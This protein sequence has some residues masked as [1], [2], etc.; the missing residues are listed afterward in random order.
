[1]EPAHNPKHAFRLGEAPLHLSVSSWDFLPNT[2]LGLLEH[3]NATDTYPLLCIS[4][5]VH[6]V[7]PGSAAA[8]SHD[9]RVQCLLFL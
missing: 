2:V 6:L 8:L 9:S 1:M 4:T 3:I 5:S 7:L